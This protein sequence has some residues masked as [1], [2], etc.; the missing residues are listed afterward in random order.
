[1]I[2]RD[3][4]KEREKEVEMG[5]EIKREKIRKITQAQM[6]VLLGKIMSETTLQR[7]TQMNASL[8]MTH[9]ITAKTHLMALIPN[10]VKDGSKM[11]LNMQCSL[12]KNLK[13]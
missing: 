8:A 9:S 2:L 13:L 11:L 6:I 7:L 10:Y 4:Y 12:D 1:M 5:R 3:R